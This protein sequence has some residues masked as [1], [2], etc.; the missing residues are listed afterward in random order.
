MIPGASSPRSTP[1]TGVDGYLCFLA[2]NE[3]VLFGGLLRALIPHELKALGNGLPLLDVRV[4]TRPEQP[5]NRAV[6][7]VPGSLS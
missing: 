6:H 3:P 1:S 7:D 4:Y 2:L 5:A